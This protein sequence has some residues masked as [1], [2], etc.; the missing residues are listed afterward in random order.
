[1][2]KELEANLKEDIT[3]AILQAQF[4]CVFGQGA[5]RGNRVKL[6]EAP[7]NVAIEN[8]FQGIC[9]TVYSNLD[10]V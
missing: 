10:W 7:A 1:M 3:A 2:L 8:N 6:F 4:P 9:E 5:I